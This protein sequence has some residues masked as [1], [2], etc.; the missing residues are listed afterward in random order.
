MV[1]RDE[2]RTGHVRR[3]VSVALGC[4]QVWNGPIRFGGAGLVTS[5]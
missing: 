4:V 3:V 2:G 1:G 5:V